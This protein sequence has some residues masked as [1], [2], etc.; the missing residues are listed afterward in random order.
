[1]ASLVAWYEN[2]G[3]G[4]TWT[5]HTLSTAPLR[6]NAL[7]APD[8]DGDG[9]PDLALGALAGAP[10]WLP[11]RGGQIALAT[12][13]TAPAQLPPG[14]RDDLLAI[15][16]GHRGRPADSDARALEIA[17]HFTDPALAP[18]TSEK[19]DTLL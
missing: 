14:R 2:W 13:V 4:F 17:L 11:N 18:L 9:D 8:L 3:F 12:A 5:A 7:L 1:H 19:L 6:P 10:A 15:D 16:V